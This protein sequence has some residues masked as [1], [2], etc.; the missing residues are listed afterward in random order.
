MRDRVHMRERGRCATGE[1]ARPFIAKLYV[2]STFGAHVSPAA[3]VFISGLTNNYD[4]SILEVTACHH[5]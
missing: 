5:I 3:I 1:D 2:K 4:Y